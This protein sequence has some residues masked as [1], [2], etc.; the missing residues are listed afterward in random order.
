MNSHLRSPWGVKHNDLSGLVEFQWFRQGPHAHI[1]RMNSDCFTSNVFWT[2][3]KPVNHR[4]I[5]S[6]YFHFKVSYN[7]RGSKGLVYFRHLFDL[8]VV[9]WI[10]RQIHQSHGSYMGTWVKHVTTH[11]TP[12]KITLQAGKSPFTNRKLY[13]PDAQWMVEGSLNRNFRQYGELK[14]RCIAQQ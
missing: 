11:N 12:D 14:S 1:D 7:P 5:T 3:L 8:L 4:D 6:M 9:L 13:I 10:C 2:L